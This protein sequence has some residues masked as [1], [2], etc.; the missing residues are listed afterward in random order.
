MPKRVVYVGDSSNTQVK[1]YE[2]QN[3]IAKYIC[4][5]HCWGKAQ[6]IKTVSKTL[7]S[8]KKEI[9]WDEL[10]TTFKHAI[11]FARKLGIQYIWIDSLCI[12][13]DSDVDWRI[14]SSNMATI[15]ENS[16]IT[17]AATKSGSGAGGCFSIASPYC[18]VR[19]LTCHDDAGAPHSICVRQNAHHHANFDSVNS[20]P[21]LHRGWV[22]QE[23]I[24]SP[25]VLHFGEQELLWECL[26][27]A[28]CECTYI[29]WYK[30]QR[31]VGP[32]FPRFMF[33][34]ISHTGKLLSQST[35]LLKARWYELVQEYTALDLTFEK[36]KF[37]ALA[38]IAKQMQRARGAK[39]LAGL[40]E[41]TLIEDLLW[42]RHSAIPSERPAKWR[43][44]T[45]SWASIKDII[46]YGSKSTY[47]GSDPIFAYAEILDV[48]CTPVGPDSTLELAS[49]HL[50]VSSYI[51]PVVLRRETFQKGRQYRHL[52]EIANVGGFS[53]GFTSDFALPE[54]MMGETVHCLWIARMEGPNRA[55]GLVLR[56]LDPI[57]RIYE[58][59]G[60]ASMML[61]ASGFEG[62]SSDMPLFSI[63]A[64]E[65]ITVKIV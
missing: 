52:S 65:R 41:D 20:N 16:Y 49:A 2:T 45:W 43:A 28:T 25:R 61:S 44:P 39:Y 64:T 34:K 13:Q 9:L 46:A 62:P 38:G 8:Y 10:S 30:D 31:G 22:F 17:L 59:I 19:E 48:Q 6:I 5:S 21:M 40:W 27:H 1:L 36:D 58:R 53:Y 18:K 33:G 14:E 57:L 15:Y 51:V 3:E 32:L 24:L 4:L 63:P 35:Q 50:V 37:P 12:I 29:E 26:E 11:I 7:P 54:D 56:C 42:W 23:R 60:M 55:L 47:D